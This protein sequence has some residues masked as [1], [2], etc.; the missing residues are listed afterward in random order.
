MYEQPPIT[1]VSKIGSVINSSCHQKRIFRN[2]CRTERLSSVRTAQGLYISTRTITYESAGPTQYGFARAQRCIV[3]EFSHCQH[4]V[5]IFQTIHI[6][7]TFHTFH[8]ITSPD[9][10]SGGVRCP[11]AF[12]A[13]S[14]QKSRPGVCPVSQ[15]LLTTL[16]HQCPHTTHRRTDDPTTAYRTLTIYQRT[17]DSRRAF[18]STARRNRP[19]RPVARLS[20]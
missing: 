14:H 3:F 12:L 6:F 8:S 11:A 16:H 2:Y 19:V 4:R 18:S 17:A 10:C 13:H 7:E 15:P 9:C 5:Y 1:I 20:R